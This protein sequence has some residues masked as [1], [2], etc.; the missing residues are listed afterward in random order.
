MGD[1]SHGRADQ[2]TGVHAPARSEAPYPPL[3]T[4]S[5]GE[6]TASLGEAQRALK[7]GDGA[8]AVAL[9]DELAAR[10]PTG[11]LREERL[12]ARVFALCAADRVEEA[13]EAGK[14]FLEELPASVQAER[15]R[16]SCAFAS[17]N[18]R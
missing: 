15:V 3:G 11:V 1:D 12:A 5:L 18:P 17:S 9:L 14:R 6:E 2:H 7:Q 4:I 10:H 13:R 8:R 16:A